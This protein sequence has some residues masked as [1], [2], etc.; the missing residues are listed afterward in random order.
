MLYGDNI[1]WKYHSGK[2]ISADKKLKK[3]YFNIK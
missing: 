2:K 1:T 3:N